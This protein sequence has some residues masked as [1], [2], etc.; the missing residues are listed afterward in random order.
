MAFNLP[1][2][3]RSSF[4]SNAPRSPFES[5]APRNSI[6]KPGK[7]A[8]S[9]ISEWAKESPQGQPTRPQL[10]APRSAVAAPS[11]PQAGTGGTGFVGFGQYFGANEPAATRSAQQ[12]AQAIGAG[13]REQAQ[14]RAS[15]G[16]SG[17][18]AAAADIARQ[19][20]QD[21]FKDFAG[22]VSPSAKAGEAGSAGAFEA[23]LA[24]RANPKA[25]AEEQKGL[26]GLANYFANTAEVQKYTEG[27][28]RSAQY[29]Q[30][31]AAEQA[32]QSWYA[33]LP[34]QYKTNYTEAELREMYKNDSSPVS[35]MLKTPGSSL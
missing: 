17:D 27:L 19:G 32:Y 4:S 1:N 7:N 12:Q 14:Q 30:R 21:A 35:G 15:G 20:A 28:E 10:V 29:R 25:A 11:A 5:N 13:V 24:G 9:V 23:M 33:D 2:N 22:G 6:V 16:R 3:P 8:Q 18:Y 31:A 34:Q 26:S